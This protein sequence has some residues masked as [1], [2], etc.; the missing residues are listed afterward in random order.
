M[1]NN[2]R[3]IYIW[4]MLALFVSGCNIGSQEVRP[5]SIGNK[6]PIEQ[7]NSDEAKQIVL[8]MEEVIEVKGVSENKNI[9]LAAKVGQ[10]DRFFLRSIRKDAHDKVKKRFPNANVHVSTDKK[11]FMELEELERKLSNNEIDE[12][13]FKKELKKVEEFMKG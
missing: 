9:Y 1:I 3:F 8:S 12:K 13:E 10:F 11:V 4:V 6:G 7:N 2:K 5:L